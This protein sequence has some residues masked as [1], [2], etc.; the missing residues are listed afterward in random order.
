MNME[1]AFQRAGL[2]LSDTPESSSRAS[3]QA[4]MPAEPN[5]GIQL[6]PHRT[7]PEAISMTSDRP[8][9]HENSTATVPPVRIM[10]A[11]HGNFLQGVIGRM[12]DLR[13]DTRYDNLQQQVFAPLFSSD[14]N[15]R[16]IGPV[17]DEITAPFP[18]MEWST[19]K[20][21]VDDPKLHSDPGWRACVNAHLAM[22]A[23]F[24]AAKSA[25]HE[26][27]GVAWAYFKTAFAILPELTVNGDGLCAI[28]AVISMAM[29]VRGSPDVQT[30]TIL[31]ST[32]GRLYQM[33]SLHRRARLIVPG[34]PEDS[35]HARVFWAL[36]ALDQELSIKHGLPPVLDKNG[37]TVPELPAYDAAVAP[38]AKA[39]RKRAKLACCET[40]I[41]E[42]LYSARSS[43]KGRQ[44]IMN[45]IQC[46]DSGFLL[47]RWRLEPGVRIELDPTTS[48]FDDL[49]TPTTIHV[50]G[51]HLAH[52]HCVQM[53]HWPSR[54][55]EDFESSE[56]NPARSQKNCAKAA[57]DAL[58]LFRHLNSLPFSSIW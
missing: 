35:R 22:T 52:Y 19:L 31:I 51:M 48:A 25:F 8:V 33:M 43:S 49:D 3:N 4:S 56:W 45:N 1:T 32:A 15:Q 36:Y 12:N 39:F 38:A 13:R 46:L 5:D 53:I 47:M 58:C 2:P 11:H 34:S 20:T 44:F 29:F 21:R 50:I 23:C 7:G 26:F 27:Q 6:P 16:F 37:A 18:Y 54:H 9:G 10:G 55:V 40:K 24:R 41:Y 30:L 28:E 57:Q 17:F 42:R 14:P